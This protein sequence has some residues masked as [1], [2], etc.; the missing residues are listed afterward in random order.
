[1]ELC[2]R[3][4]SLSGCQARAAR[5]MLMW[6]VQRLARASNISDSSIRRIESA[7]GVP[8]HV[9]LD[10]LMRLRIYFESRGFTFVFDNELGPGVHW[11]YAA[12]LSP[13]GR[14]QDRRNGERRQTKKRSFGGSFGGDALESG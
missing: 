10:L 9:T 14:A 6:S 12:R 4:K 2:M 7:F 13:D 8:E 11:R 1:M 5:A 3:E